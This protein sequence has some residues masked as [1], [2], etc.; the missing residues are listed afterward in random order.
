MS[1]RI[2]FSDALVTAKAILTEHAVELPGERI[3]I[4]RDLMGRLHLAL[5]GTRDEKATKKI[6]RDWRGKLGAYAP[7][8]DKSAVFWRDEMFDPDAVFANSDAHEICEL[9]DKKLLLLDR[10]FI[11]LDWLRPEQAAL[12]VRTITFYGLKGGVGRSTAL[13]AFAWWMAKQG[14]R[15]L[16]VDLDLESP[17][18]SHTLL[19]DEARPD[20]GVVDWLVEDAVGQADDE[21]LVNMIAPG[22]TTPSGDIRVVPALGAKTTDFLP[23]LARAYGD[24]RGLN[25]VEHFGQRLRRL[26]LA[27]IERTSCDLLILDSRAGLHDIAAVTI[28]H[29]SD[30]ALLFATSSRQTWGGYTELLGNW[31]RHPEI[32]RQVREKLRVVAALVPQT[33]EERKRYL[34][35]LTDQSWECL[36]MLYDEVPPP[37]EEGSEAQGVAD[38]FNFD[39]DDA[40]APHSLLPIYWR[41]E[42]VDADFIN[43]PELLEDNHY[44]PAFGD[45]V[46]RLSVLAGVQP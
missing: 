24:T 32:A 35:T 37:T 39:R 20:Y 10:Q 34:E 12:P 41:P 22:P 43:Q 7:A 40:D 15:I 36:T 9:A 26:C 18:V 44:L 8:S 45:F 4:V 31:S 28:T 16:V 1:T 38:Y 33:T 46:K 13:S 21:L 3:V 27:L 17:G 19:A 2:R 30:I 42:F 6:L 25:G 11:G 23:K 14:K 29:L 5:E